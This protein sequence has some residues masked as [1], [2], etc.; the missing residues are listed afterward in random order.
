[1]LGY[2]NTDKPTDPEIYKSSLISRDIVDLLDAESID[3]SA[4]VIGHDWG[5]K[6]IARLA[7][8]FPQRF[9]AF[10]FLTV[11]NFPGADFRMP[12]SEIN[13]N[14]KAVFGYEPFGYQ[15]FW[16]NAVHM[17]YLRVIWIRG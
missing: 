17:R 8:Y 7:N 2:G 11:G 6:I 4:V 13:K 10:G 5:A 9:S 15:D 16:R 12:H 1:M 14:T 3:K